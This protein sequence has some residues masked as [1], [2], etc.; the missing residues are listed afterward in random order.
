M[1]DGNAAILQSGNLFMYVMHNPVMFVDPTGLFG[2]VG[3]PALVP[4]VAVNDEGGGGWTSMSPAEQEEL[5]Q[6][7]SR[8]P[9]NDIWEFLMEIGADAWDSWSLDLSYGMGFGA[10]VK[11]GPFASGKAQLTVAEFTH[12]FS[13]SGVD[14]RFG[15]G[16]EISIT[17]ASRRYGFGFGGRASSSIDTMRQYGLMFA[18][19]RE[20]EWFIGPIIAG[21]ALIGSLNRQHDGDTVFTLG[22]SGYLV[23]G[24]GI[25]ISFNQSEF[26]RLRRARR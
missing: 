25:S 10:R 6:A 21:N 4:A 15:M 5:I 23:Y 3:F 19:D 14:G 17:D 7:I 26:E 20:S 11:F 18:P 24:G 22:V 8:L 9:W 12:T 2:V 1:Q 13:S 16:A